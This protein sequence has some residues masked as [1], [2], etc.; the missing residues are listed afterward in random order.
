MGKKAKTR[1]HRQR[2][3]ARRRRHPTEAPEW[4]RE[5]A[6]LALRDIADKI[7]AHAGIPMP[8]EDFPIVVED[9]YPWG[10]A[11][12]AVMPGSMHRPQP[13]EL[14]D[15]E[16]VNVVNSWWSHGRQAQ[17]FLYRDGAGRLRHA[18]DYAAKRAGRRLTFWL[19]T[20]GASAGWSYRDELRAMEKLKE[21]LSDHLFGMYVTTGTF[22]E[23]SP[24]SGVTYMLRRA[25]PTVAMVPMRRDDPNS[26][27]KILAVLCMHPVGLY[28]NTWAGAMVPTD[29][30]IAHL[31]WIRADEHGF[32]RR[33]NQHQY[34]APEAGL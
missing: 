2:V 12:D 30:V 23:T 26:S 4:N 7:G 34:A 14:E 6:N 18:L 9:R 5:S 8:V 11:L 17:V 1:Q 21:M 33:A 3:E 10:D 16:Q 31:L 27:M 28:A 25:R 24:R 13:D 15:G 22:L 19:N 20:A 32:W 29:D